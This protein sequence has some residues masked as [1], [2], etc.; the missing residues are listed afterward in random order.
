MARKR[1]GMLIKNTDTLPV[2]F[3]LATRILELGPGQAVPITAEEVR[4]PVL[5]EK[6]QAREISIVRPIS[7][8]EE[9]AILKTLG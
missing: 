1:K 6:L 7:E 5:R 9:E 4:D 3:K 8:A 2:S